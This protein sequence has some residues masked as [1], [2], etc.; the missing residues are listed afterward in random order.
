MFRKYEKTFRLDTPGKRSLTKAELKQLLSGLV[1]VEEK[2]DGAN[3][4]IIRHK[5]GFHLQKRN[6][7]VAE[8]EHAQFQFFNAWAHSGAF[9]RIM[10][11]PIGYTVYGE[12]LR[13]VH[14][15]HYPNLPDWFVVF[16]VWDGRKYM[17]SEDKREF[18]HDH[19]FSPVPLIAEGNFSLQDIKNL[20]P[21]QSYFGPM[22]EGIVV[23]KY[24]K[25]HKRFM[26]GKWINPEFH[27]AMDEKH[28]TTL[29]VRLN[30]LAKYR[31]VL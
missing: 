1:V 4:G 23:K 3:A 19:G 31:L 18:C 24:H 8:S 30:G 6:S 29:P 12:L 28:W 9:E 16:D 10:G 22:C 15:I 5:R 11:L 20:V 2:L 25:D 26:K 7:L 13:C 27:E 14:T 17:G 21:R